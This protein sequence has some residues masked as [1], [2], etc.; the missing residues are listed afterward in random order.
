VPVTAVAVGTPDGVVNQAL[1]GG[2]TER[3]Q[4]PVKPAALQTIARASNGRFVSGAQFV[5]VD[6]TYASLKQRA[7]HKRK[8]V[9]VTS[10]AAGGGLAF[11]VAA[12]LLSGVWFRRLT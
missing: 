12:A 11:M 7:G 2:F 1:K 3:F 5:N 9:E 10:A 8:A 4:V 6:A